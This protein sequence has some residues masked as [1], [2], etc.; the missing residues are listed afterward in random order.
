MKIV[1]NTVCGGF[2]LSE[3]A[4]RLIGESSSIITRDD[5][6]LIAAVEELGLLASGPYAELHI[7]EIP[8]GVCWEIEEYDGAE[9]VS[10]CHRRWEYED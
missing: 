3:A 2:G 4:K 8:D 5:P 6:K 1:I 9:W 10:E 7:I